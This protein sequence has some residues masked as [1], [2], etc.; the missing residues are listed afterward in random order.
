[1]IRPHD[2]HDPEGFVR[3]LLP[4]VGLAGG[5]RLPAELTRR[6]TADTVQAARVPA[7]VHLALVGDAPALELDVRVGPA[8]SGLAPSLP[9]TFR[10]RTETASS[11]V[12]LPAGGGVVRVPLPPRPAGTTV[13]IYLPEHVE[14][15]IRSLSAVGGSIEPAPR[16]PRFVVYGDSI[17]QGWSVSEQGLSW[18][19][20]VSERFGLDLIN[21]GFAGSAR[22][23]LPAA[24]AVARSAADLVA[25]A[26]G[27]NAW[28]T[29]PADAGA[30][31]ET[32]RLFLTVV[33]QG[34]PDAPLVVLS[35]IVRPEAEE[36]GNRFGATVGDLRDALEEAVSQ[37]AERTGDQRTHLVPGAHLVPSGDLVDGLHPGD[38]GHAH[39]AAGVAPHVAAALGRA[40]SST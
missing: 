31:R 27:T 9:P 13:R 30:I 25:I 26:W 38:S 4:A 15:D 20:L 19:C 5:S 29:L 23:E 35:P 36:A 7:G 10:V 28:V 16:G 22:G 12:E 8:T 18:P 1:M 37:F 34:L 17:T 33:R 14:L 6:L 40:R 39:L 11:P 3:G 32:M 2:P 21:L 24:E